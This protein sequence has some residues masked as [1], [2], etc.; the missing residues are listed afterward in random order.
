MLLHLLSMNIFFSSFKQECVF[1]L[2]SVEDS[3]V[4]F[5][6]ARRKSSF[7]SLL[8]LKLLF[9]K[10]SWESTKEMS[11]QGFMVAYFETFYDCQNN[12]SDCMLLE[13]D[14][15]RFTFANLVYEFFISLILCS[16]LIGSKVLCEKLCNS[17]EFSFRLF[18]QVLISENID[19][20]VPL[21]FPQKFSLESSYG[22]LI[23][24][25]YFL[26]VLSLHKLRSIVLLSSS[27]FQK[28]SSLIFGNLN[29]FLTLIVSES[30]FICK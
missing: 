22:L 30:T 6:E 15:L 24:L 4:I 11:M 8:E 17:D 26:R 20:E 9:L 14:R 1:Y 7:W 13:D 10:L 12:S 16:I 3:V 19:F 2:E 27:E 28:E 29:D 23:T 25:K 21:F 18:S 5:V